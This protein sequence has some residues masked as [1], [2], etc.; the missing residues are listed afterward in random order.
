MDERVSYKTETENDDGCSDEAGGVI[1]ECDSNTWV[2]S[3][4]NRGGQDQEA[5]K[6]FLNFHP[7]TFPLILSF[8]NHY[9]IPY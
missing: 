1:A 9:S 6:L 4:T 7:D 8:E 3:R 2:P 5:T